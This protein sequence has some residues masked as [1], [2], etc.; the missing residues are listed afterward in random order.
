MTYEISNKLFAVRSNH[1]R[2]SIKKGVLENFAKL[3]GKHLYQ[4]LLFI[5][6]KIPGT[7]IFLRIWTTA[8]IAEEHFVDFPNLS[9]KKA[10]KL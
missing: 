6:K 1:R 3:T 8:S 5:K 9:A 4:S 10:H 2:C 7:S